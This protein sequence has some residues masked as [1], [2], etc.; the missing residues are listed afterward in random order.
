VAADFFQRPGRKVVV[1]HVSLKREYFEIL[2]RKRG[3]KPSRLANPRTHV[4][5]ILIAKKNIVKS[6]AITE[7]LYLQSAPWAS[8]KLQTLNIVPRFVDPMESFSVW[9]PNFTPGTFAVTRF[10]M[11]WAIVR[12]IG[13][14]ARGNGS[15]SSQFSSGYTV[16]GNPNF[17]S[18]AAH[19]IALKRQ[20]LLTGSRAERCGAC[21]NPISDLMSKDSKL[22]P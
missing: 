10:H 5:N 19:A 12:A 18:D 2:L 7:S 15:A 16:H 14:A 21:T 20:L 4:H 3:E 1:G 8:S 13:L 11:H 9:S 6:H 17:A 22:F